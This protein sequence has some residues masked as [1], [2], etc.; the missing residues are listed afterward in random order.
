MRYSNNIERKYRVYSI[1]YRVKKEKG[2]IE[3]VAFFFI[4]NY[5]TKVYINIFYFFPL[6]KI[7]LELI[8]TNLLQRIRWRY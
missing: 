4:S 2:K 3:K 6:L 7:Y 5:P 1:E 8:L